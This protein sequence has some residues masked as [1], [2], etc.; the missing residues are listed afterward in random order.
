MSDVQL[1]ELAAYAERLVLPPDLRALESRGRAARDRRRGAG[2]ALVLGLVLTGLWLLQHDTRTIIEPVR[3]PELPLRGQSYPGNQMQDLPA[4]TYELRP[5]S[6]SGDPS[7]LITLPAGWNS[8]EGPNKFDGHRPGDPTLGRYNEAALG[9]S[10]WYVGALVVKLV[11]V[12]DTPCQFRWSPD[13]FV[14]TVAGQVQAL[15]HLPGYRLVRPAETVE[16][17]GYP[18]HHFV[19]RSTPAAEACQRDSTLYL[20]SRNGAL[21]GIERGEIWLVDVDGVP[22]TVFRSEEGD[23]PPRVEAEL[24]A[25]VAS[26]RIVFGED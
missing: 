4:G 26:I 6:V 2:V 8:W 1:R 9:R 16:A 21:G 15:G 19:Y 18:A 20:S 3:P 25:V 5:S 12:S 7:A 11:A 14:D 13:D 17:F 23:V 24:D 22:I 10:N